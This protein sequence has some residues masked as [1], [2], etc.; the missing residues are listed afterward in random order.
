M[1]FVCP[2]RKLPYNDT[3]SPYEIQKQCIAGDMKLPRDIDQATRDLL[4]CIF[5]VE[6]NLR[7]TIK[8]IM[9]KAFFKD[10]NWDKVRHLNIDYESI[11]YHANENKYR[12][13]LQNKY[14]DVSN[15]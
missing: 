10:I 5:Q 1:C 9:K 11:P 4:N 6:P 8:D 3:E 15:L 7:I 13:I 12:Y 14:D 2:Y